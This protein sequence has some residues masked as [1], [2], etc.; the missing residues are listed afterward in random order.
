M[1]KRMKDRLD[2]DCTG[3][4]ATHAHENLRTHV[5]IVRHYRRVYAEALA[6]DLGFY[7]ARHRLTDAIT[8]AGAAH[9]SD[10]KK[11]PH[12]WRLQ[13]RALAAATAR[14]RQA[15]LESP[16]DFDELYARVDKALNPVRGVGPLYIYD[17]ALRIG[18][19][20]RLLPERIYLHA[21]T[22][23]G[24]RALGLDHRQDAVSLD[25]LP[26]CFHGLQPHEVEDLLCVYKI[27][28]TTIRVPPR[29]SR[30]RR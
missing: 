1:T 18:A 29:P 3:S 30:R 24:A 12:Q 4:R 25:A 5:A 23:V 26:A 7:R 8:H 15:R 28:L 6:R 21:G 19:Y 10:E 13:H 17:T 20:R 11:H 22:R 16:R 14:L 27:Q 2:T 9:Q